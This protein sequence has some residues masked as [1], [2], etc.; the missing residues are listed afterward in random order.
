M[1]K[2]EGN[3]SSYVLTNLERVGRQYQ[4][5][6]INYK[7]QVVVNAIKKHKSGKGSMGCQALE[8]LAEGS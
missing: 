1:N 2:I 6:Q 4:D 7:C 8:N 5:K 3:F